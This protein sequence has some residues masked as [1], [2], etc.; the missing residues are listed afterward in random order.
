MHEIT[1]REYARLTTESV[2]EESLD[3]AQVTASAF[4]WLC[5]LNSS[6]TR[7]GAAL[8]QIEGRRW[9][10][11]DN[12]VG[13]L[14]SPC[15]T[16]L[17]ILPKHFDAGD[18]TARSRALLW[19]MIEAASDLSVR[20]VGETALQ[21]FDKPL[22]EWVI[23][24]FLAGLD[25]LVKRG[26]RSDYLRV[27]AV[28]RYQRGQLDVVR[29]M[30]Q[31]PGRGHLFH[32]RHDVFVHDWPENRLL[33]SALEQVCRLTQ[34]SANWR[35]AQELRELFQ[36]IPA[37]RDIS[38]DFS[39][40]RSDRLNAHYKPVRPWCELILYRQMP[41]SLVGQWHG[42]SMLFPMEKLFERYVAALLRRTLASD[43]RLVAQAASKSLCEHAGAD[44]FRLEP[45]LL[46]ERASQKWILDTKW[47]RLDENDR[48]EKY[49][50]R[51]S[52][53]Y[54]LY[55]Y[56]QK[57]LMGNGEMALIF[58]KCKTFTKPLPIFN[59]GNGLSLWVLPFDLEAGRLL[60][61][62]LTSLPFGAQMTGL[63]M[64]NSDADVAMAAA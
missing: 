14:E 60:H 47:K 54:Q 10:K 28:E 31:P 23:G 8:V 29:Q 3:R 22:S 6:F 11:L 44:I 57:Y 36:D 41:L 34:S 4:D 21:V 17:E 58:P 7:S 24:R 35:I 42:I 52:D 16:R 18:D 30:R 50:L 13:V 1:V 63:P 32:I 61:G 5:T 59:Y 20:E 40:W 37:S 64:S 56:G 55:A 45:D 43:A 53:F 48:S 49:G 2:A 27:E 33:K 62:G 12:Y 39:L 51:Q 25:H 15:G 46:I 26:V 19:R 38:S 9:L